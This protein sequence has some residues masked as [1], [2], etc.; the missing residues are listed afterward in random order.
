MTALGAGVTILP[1]TSTG[2]QNRLA[3]QLVIRPFV[4][5]EPS[6]TV[7]LAYRR[8]FP[9]PQ[10]IAVLAESIRAAPP[11]GVTPKAF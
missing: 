9:R 10:A 1:V 2:A 7:A 11:D 5:P 3:D 6:R 8:T 4:K